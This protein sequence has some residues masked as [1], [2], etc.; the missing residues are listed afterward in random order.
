M[1]LS[2]EMSRG[3]ARPS[4]TD[5]PDSIGIG[6]E[7][8]DPCS[9][10]LS[11]GFVEQPCKL[12]DVPRAVKSLSVY[13]LSV[14]PW[15]LVLAWVSAFASL[16]TMSTVSI[17][18]GTCLISVFGRPVYSNQENLPSLLIPCHTPASSP[19]ADK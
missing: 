5:I 7:I 12:Y 2:I 4:N 19:S 16:L 15:T 8:V 17:L 9:S 3:S 18:Q 11:Q 13:R 6:V 1:V 10:Q 14:C